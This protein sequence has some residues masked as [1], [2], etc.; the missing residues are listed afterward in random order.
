MREDRPSLLARLLRGLDGLRRFLVNVLFFGL[1]A[2]LVAA[3]MGG[4][5]KVPDGA[6]LVV[7]PQ[8]V[9]VERT[10]GRVVPLESTGG[11]SVKGA[12]GR[13]I[14]LRFNRGVIGLAF[15]TL[16]VVLVLLP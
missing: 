2:G 12:S 5:P 1:L 16:V 4:R 13:E 7:K 3:G 8:G 14:A 11:Q 9:I 15:L 10:T 6:A